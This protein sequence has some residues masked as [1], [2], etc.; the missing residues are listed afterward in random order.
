MDSTKK[1]VYTSKLKL[2]SIGSNNLQLASP[3]TTRAKLASKVIDLGVFLVPL[4]HISLSM[5]RALIVRLVIWVW[6]LRDN[7]GRNVAKGETMD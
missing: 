7:V 1:R 4:K 5:G 6:I 3:V 2:A